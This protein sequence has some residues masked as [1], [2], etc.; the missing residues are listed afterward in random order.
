MKSLVIVMAGCL[1]LHPVSSAT[2]STSQSNENATSD[3]SAS[4]L[5]SE[6]QKVLETQFPTWEIQEASNLSQ[7]AKTR[8]QAEKPLACPGIAIG[9]FEI[10]QQVS[11]GV[12]LVPK[13][14]P[15]SAYKLL[16]FTPNSSHTAN[17]LKT[18]DDF[19]QGGASN[20]FIHT[21]AIGKVFST[22]WIKKLKV[23]TKNGILA[24]D[25]GENE[26]GIDVFFWNGNEYRHEPI[27]Y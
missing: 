25:S 27:D 12:L 8:W 2:P 11:Y 22:E 23:K 16:V 7:H 19:A 4:Q 18:L 14:N 21:I 5:P 26:Y 6:L 1:T 3:C 20:N 13:N 10:P 24:A 17:G 9:Q 15:D